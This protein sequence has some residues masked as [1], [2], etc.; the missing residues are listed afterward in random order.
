MSEN[1]II[2]EYIRDKYPEM[3]G[4]ADF[5]L[6]KMALALRGVA[7]SIVEAFQKLD[8]KELQKVADMADSIGKE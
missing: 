4:T 8:L 7:S 1:D 3:L 2:A 5:A 6:Y